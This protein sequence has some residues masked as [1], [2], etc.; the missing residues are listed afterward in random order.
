VD[1]YGKGE[2][3]LRHRAPGGGLGRREDHPRPP[4]ALPPPTEGASAEAASGAEEL[5]ETGQA[6]GCPTPCHAGA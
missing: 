5:S 2:A 4:P 6:G 3:Q 1:S